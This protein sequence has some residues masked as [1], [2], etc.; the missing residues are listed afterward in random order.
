MAP[1][2]NKEPASGSFLSKYGISRAQHLEVIWAQSREKSAWEPGPGEICGPGIKGN[3]RPG[4]LYKN[5][6]QRSADV[7]FVNKRRSTKY[8]SVL[9]R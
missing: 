7:C 1:L 8:T 9:R 6:Q 2:P 5:K 3:P 4:C